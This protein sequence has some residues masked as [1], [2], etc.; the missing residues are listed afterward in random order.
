MTDVDQQLKTRVSKS[1]S[2][3]GMASTVVSILDFVAIVLILRFWLTKSEYGIATMAAWMFAILDYASDLGLSAA[4][5]QRDDHTREKLSTVFWANVLVSVLMIGLLAALHPV[6][7]GFYGHTIV[8]NMILAYGAKL[9]WQNV[10]LIPQALMRK[11]LRY[12]ELSVIRLIANLAEFSGKIGFASAGFGPWSLVLGPMCRFFVVGVG[13]QLRRPWRPALVCRVRDAAE[14]LRFGFKA[15]GSQMLFYFYTNVDYA[16]V[17]RVFGDA[18]LGMYRWAYEV[19][20]EPVRIISDV[21]REVAFAA[22]ARLRRDPEQIKAQFISF[23]RLNL[24][25]VLTFLGVVVV[26]AEEVLILTVDQDYLPAASAIRI[27]AL[28][29]V[30]RSVGFVVPPMLD[31]LG[32]PGR[33]LIYQAC[34]AV[35]LP[36]LF[37]TGAS[38]LGD[39]MGFTS[40]AVAWA[41]GYPL[42]FSVLMAMGLYAAHLRVREY[43]AKIMGIPACVAAAVAAGVVAKLALGELSVGLRFV[44]IITAELAVLLPLLTYTQKMSPRAMWRA[45]RGK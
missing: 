33:T 44:G 18:A 5:I 11:E 39:S 30:L 38:V 13:T 14:Y 1:L 15:S 7:A 21:V 23:T 24:F 22:F 6:F 36:A 9:L 37:V 20:L 3:V 27:L 43:L 41:V 34:A 10:Y 17:G 8:A 29:G 32:F 45:A 4:V 31:G 16:I 12:G 42:A 28:V 35:L 26:A 2:W 19:V 25:T 40:M